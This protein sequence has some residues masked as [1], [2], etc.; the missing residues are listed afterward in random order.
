ME[1]YS[2]RRKKEKNPAICDTMDGPQGL[3]AKWEKSEK[4]KYCIFLLICGI[5][6]AE[7]IKPECEMVF[8]KGWG[9]RK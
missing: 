6:K 2:V 5:W 7:L 1:Y 9:V 4:D 8:T 3:Y